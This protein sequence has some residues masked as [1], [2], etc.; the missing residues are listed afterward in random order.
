M[1]SIRLEDPDGA[2][3][4]AAASRPVP[5][6]APA[7]RRR[8]A[9]GAA[10]LLALGAARRR[11]LPDHRQARA[12]RRRQ[13]L[14]AHAGSRV[15][16][17]LDIAAPR[18]TFILDRTRRAGAADQ[19][20]HR[21]H[22]GARHAAR[23]GAGAF[24]P[25]DLVAARRAQQPRPRLRRRGPRPPRLAAERAHP[26]LLQPSGPG[27]RR[28]PRLRRAPAGS[29][30]RCSPSSSRRA[31]PRRTC[32]G[33]RRSWRRSAPAWPRSASTPRASTPSRSGPHPA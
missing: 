31:T 5:H 23:A 15:G 19:R 4:P 21:R 20:R 32:A 26:R 3:L 22:A 29:P 11:L 13:R 2:P 33:R 28:G 7:A 25:G 17:Q 9:V 12:R 27:R 30:R 18:G 10:Q 1:I 14:P 6:A 16:D 24:R 8:A